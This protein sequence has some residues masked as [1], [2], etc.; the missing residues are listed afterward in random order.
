MREK[1]TVAAFQAHSR[2]EIETSNRPSY[3]T[4]ALKSNITS[5]TCVCIYMYIEREKKYTRAACITARHDD[6]EKN[7]P[8]ARSPPLRACNRCQSKTDIRADTGRVPGVR[9][10]AFNC[11]AGGVTL[12]HKLPSD[13]SRHSSRQP[14]KTP[15][16]PSERLYILYTIRRLMREKSRN[17]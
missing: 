1:I 14:Y 7:D 15:L 5:D 8:R 13:C 17:S 9:S 4:L 10:R 3:L 16:T 6:A 2:A 11:L 12:R